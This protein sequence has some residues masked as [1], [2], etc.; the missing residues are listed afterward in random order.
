MPRLLHQTERLHRLL[1]RK[2][3]AGQRFHLPLRQQLH[4]CRQHL[5]PQLRLLHA[6]FTQV[7]D[8]VAHIRTHA[9]HLLHTPDVALA[10]LRQVPV[11]RQHGQVRFHKAGSCERIQDDVDAAAARV[12]QYLRRK[13]NRA[14]V[15]DVVDPHGAQH[16]PLART[17]GGKHLGPRL[18]RQ[19]YGRHAHT[20]GR[21]MNQHPLARLHLRQLM[22]PVVGRQVRC[23][24]RRGLHHRERRRP[25]RHMG[26]VDCHITAE[27]AC[28]HRQHIVAGR[29][30]RD[31]LAHGHHNPGAFTADRPGIAGVCS[32]HIEHI[33]E[34]HAARLHLYLDFPAC[35]CSA[36]DG[37]QLQ[38]VQHAALAHLQPVWPLRHGQSSQSR[39]R[40]IALQAG[41]I[42]G[43]RT[44]GNLPFR[45]GVRANRCDFRIQLCCR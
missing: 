16:L 20:A 27:A 2:H 36:C 33:A 26:A 32:Q 37:A 41:H 23:R 17:G 39:S 10:H 45:R 13:I 42:A 6:D 40:R 31:T 24:Q 9:S 28:R 15:V 25:V 43:V 8:G 5:L 38:I 18:L 3:R 22:Q 29:K 7:K 21:R 14:R 19:L 34:V 12:G 4:D 30:V 11:C 44:Q 1:Q 35:R